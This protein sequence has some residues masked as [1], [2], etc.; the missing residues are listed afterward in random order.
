MIISLQH[1]SRRYEADLSEPLD[2]SIP[3][4]E[5]A[6]NPEC[7][8]ADAPVFEVIRSGDF[9]GSVKEG[10]NVNHHK[11]HITPHG[12]GTHTECL[13]HLTAD[14][15]TINNTLLQCHFIAE[16][17]T[18]TPQSVQGDAVITAD[19]LRASLL[20]A[21][22]EAVVIRTLPNT[23]AKCTQNY[24]GTNPPYLSQEAAELLAERK[25]NHLLI[26][27]PS[28]D[29]EVDGGRL[30]AHKAF[31]QLPGARRMHATITELIYVPAEI[32]D[33]LYLLNLQ[34][35]SLELDASP[36]KP[37]LYNLREVL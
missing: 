23:P 33:G 11:I 15:T 36:S 28:V 30:E 37:I 7:Y 24:S 35:T 4:R 10:G 14:D 22:A 21:D 31:W 25:V 20:H 1:K 8:W 6:N 29:K 32:G 16:L 17:I 3:L 12:N 27:L 13:G 19:A 18:V 26:D 2:I 34:V 5:G 9:I